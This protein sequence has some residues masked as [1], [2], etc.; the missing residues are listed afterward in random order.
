MSAE[1]VKLSELNLSEQKVVVGSM[2]EGEKRHGGRG[3]A[4]GLIGALILFIFLVLIIFIILV[5]W[6][7]RWLLRGR[8]KGS[9]GRGS[10]EDCKDKEE[11]CVDYSKAFLWSIV[12]AIVLIIL[13]LI[14]GGITAGLLKGC[15]RKRH[16]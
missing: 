5:A 4:G 2:K 12:V 15:W 7:P 8:G 14:L 1:G 11:H 13:F 6:G 16:S 10:R 3:F 9:F